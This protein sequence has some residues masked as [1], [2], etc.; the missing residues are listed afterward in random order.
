MSLTNHFTSAAPTAIASAMTN[1]N[2]SLGD[3]QFISLCIGIVVFGILL[4]FFCPYDDDRDPVCNEKWEKYGPYSFSFLFGYVV[5]CF[6]MAHWVYYFGLP[7]P[8]FFTFGQAI[9]KVASAVCS[10]EDPDSLPCSL[11]ALLE[12]TTRFFAGCR[13][14]ELGMLRSAEKQ[15]VREMLVI[16]GAF[17]LFFLAMPSFMRF[18]IK[19]GPEELEPR[20]TAFLDLEKGLMCKKAET[21]SD[22]FRGDISTRRPNFK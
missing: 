15:L 12:W 7:I 3:Y 18:A 2:W 14:A 19:H 1:H 22:K 8:R 20:P 4:Y 21:V 6:A 11:K 17:V 13:G 16:L 5:V 9:G 10:P